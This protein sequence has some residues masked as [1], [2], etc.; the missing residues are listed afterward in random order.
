MIVW[1]Q[2]ARPNAAQNP[3]YKL[4]RHIYISRYVILRGA[5]P[6]AIIPAS[7]SPLSSSVPF[8]Q[9]ASVDKNQ[10]KIFGHRSPILQKSCKVRSGFAEVV[11]TDQSSANWHKT[12]NRR[13]TR[14]PFVARAEIGEMNDGGFRIHARTT[15]ISLNGCFL[16][17]ANP[18]PVGQQVVVKIFTASDYFEAGATV[19]YSQPNLG[20]GIEFHEVSRHFQPTLQRSLLE[21]MRL[22]LLAENPNS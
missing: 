1:R 14:Y 8:P 4:I 11:L 15:E 17:M 9:L 22:A 2:A 12:D 3:A 13:S 16:D 10:C 7:T 21:G 5:Y 19:V 20:V 6:P 18:L